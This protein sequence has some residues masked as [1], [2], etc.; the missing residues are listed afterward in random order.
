ML[1][2]AGTKKAKE[3]DLLDEWIVVICYMT[4]KSV[5]KDFKWKNLKIIPI[6]WNWEEE[7]NCLEVSYKTFLLIL[8]NNYNF[9]FRKFTP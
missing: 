6:K 7:N 8:L 9:S 2:C 1:K 3:K 4:I 5:E